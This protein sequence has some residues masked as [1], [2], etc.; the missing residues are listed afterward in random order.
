MSII[1]QTDISTQPE[2]DA[3]LISLRKKNIISRLWEHDHTIWK[4]DPTEITN[5]LGWL[6]IIAAMHQELPRMQA[7]AKDLQREGYTNVL[8]LGMGG[9][10]LA[11]E[12]FSNTFPS[13]GLKLSVLDSTDPETVQA[14]TDSID[15]EKTLFIVA[16]KSGGTVETLSFFKYFYNLLLD[17][18]GPDQAGEH[19]VAITDPGSK[20]VDLGENYH[21]REIFLNDSNIGGRYSVLSFFGL[22]PAALAGVDVSKLLRRAQAMAELCG[23]GTPEKENPGAVLGTLLGLLA[24][25][26]RDKVTFFASRSIADFPNW[27]EQLIAESTGKEGVGILPVV[28]EPL[29]PPDVYGDDRFFVNLQVED[30]ATHSARFK[31]LEDAGHPLLR[32][33]LDDIYDLGGQFFLWEFATAVASHFLEINPFDQPDVESAKVLARQMVATY[34]ETG[35]LPKGEITPPGPKV[36]EEFLGSIQPGDYVAFQAY[37]HPTPEVERILQDI[38]L[39]THKNFKAA[40]TLGF[41]PRFLHSTGQLHKGDAGNGLFIQFTS[42]P[43]KDID[44]PDEAG[45]AASAMSFGTLK[46]SQALGDAQALRDAGRRVICIPLGENPVETLKLL[47]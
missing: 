32:L 25:A 4:S 19:F 11:P 20:L 37:V 47:K 31:T 28:A 44:I 7:L 43:I 6:H 15:L 22:V 27:V 12:V 13:T 5:R 42:Q 34:R 8:L 39:G 35:Q 33:Q 2:I 1:I 16:T 41:G 29:G 24:K 26:G 14:A 17:I 23:P 18:T 46:M 45:K 40:T 30:D 38:R 21:F 10:S 3:G 9:S 36:L